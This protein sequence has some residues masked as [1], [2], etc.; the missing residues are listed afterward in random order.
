MSFFPQLVAGPI[1]RASNLLPQFK[2]KRIF[3]YNTVV[4]GLRQILWGFFKKIVIADTCAIYANLI[5]NDYNNY[6]GF[7]LFFGAVLF[8]FQ[9]YG[10]FSGYSDIAIG[11]ARLF[12]FNLTQ[13]FNFYTFQEILLNFGEDGIFHYQ[14]GSEIIY[15]YH[16]VEVK[17]HLKKIRNVFIIFIISGFWHGKLDIYSLGRLKRNIFLT[18]FNFK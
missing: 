15:I 18:T 10:D 7:A 16:L 6:S 14:L 5:F 8:A 17:D 11:T 9:I 2:P 3:N 12:G 13:N 1:E 4:D